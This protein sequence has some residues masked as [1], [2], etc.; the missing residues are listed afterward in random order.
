M[1][2]PDRSTARR[3]RILPVLVL[4]VLAG[5]CFDFLMFARRAGASVPASVQTADAVVALTGGSGLRIAAGVDLVAKGRGAR[6]L[7]S[8]VNPDVTLDDLIALAG[9]A[10]ETYACCVDIGY[11]AET[12]IGNAEETAVWAYEHGYTRLVIVTS[13]YHMPRSLLLLQRAMPDI[14]LQPYPVRTVVDP[15]A[16]LSDFR[17]FRGVLTEWAKWR[18]TGLN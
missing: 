13:D 3:S 14:E 12:T 11:R 15:T 6:L 8:G 7:I 17:S 5:V 10:P 16:V 9:G 2:R 18:V 1:S 4:L